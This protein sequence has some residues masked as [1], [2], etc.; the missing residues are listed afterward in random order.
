MARQE[1]VFEPCWKMA[2]HSHQKDP[3]GI[4]LGIRGNFRFVKQYLRCTSESF[5][6]S[7]NILKTSKSVHPPFPAFPTARS[8]GDQSWKLRKHQCFRSVITTD[9]LKLGTGQLGCSQRMPVFRLHSATPFQHFFQYLSL[10]ITV[11]WTAATHCQ[12]SQAT[13]VSAMLRRRS[14]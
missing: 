9:K 10:N 14:T 2:E 3:T 8:F 12:S 13:S 11:H 4:L 7:K 1:F 5:I 6:I